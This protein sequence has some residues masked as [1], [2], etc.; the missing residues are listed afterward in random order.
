MWRALGVA[1][2]L[3]LTGCRSLP[4]PAA[5]VP[6]TVEK[7][8]PVPEELSRDCDIHKKR[9]NTYGELKRLRAAAVAAAKECNGRLA[10]IRALGKPQEATK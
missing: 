7:I 6:V 10:K 9:N 3:L 5:I 8:V 2:V 4:P 1:A